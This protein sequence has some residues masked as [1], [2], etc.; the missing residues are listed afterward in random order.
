MGT[1]DFAVPT[2]RA[3]ATAGHAVAA[4]YTREPARGGRGMGLRLSPVHALAAELDVPVLTP[5]GLKGD[6]AAE[7]FEA[8]GADVAVVVAYGLILPRRVLDAPRLGCLNLHASILPRWRGAAPIQR[9][10]MAGDERSGAMVMRMEAGLDTGPVALAEAVPVGPDITAGD[11]HDLLAPVGARL[12]VEAL[13]ALGR[14]TLAFAPQAETGV[15]Y[16]R[17]I[18]KTETRIDWGRPA[19]R[20]HDHVRGLSPV[21]GAWFEADLGSGVE[22][23]K[24]L[25]TT[26]LPGRAA[27]AAG[28]VGPGLSVVCGDGGAVRLLAVQR[29][30]KGVLDATAFLR[31][32]RLP[33]G[34]RLPGP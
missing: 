15:T 27:G 25:R 26:R 33:E 19:G 20:V 21:P 7:T 32:A 29:A 31:G 22:R 4:V 13:A 24:V 34:T 17:K 12:V 10:V 5:R 11:L 8:H 30:G 23:V 14:G 1:P 18:D 6:E 16:A 9:A 3:V 28:T 2:L